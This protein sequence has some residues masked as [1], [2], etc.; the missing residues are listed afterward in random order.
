MS[1]KVIGCVLVAIL[2]AGLGLFGPTTALAAPANDDFDAATT[3]GALPFSD[4]ADTRSATAAAD[5][6]ISCSNN[7][8]VWYS[9]TVSQ[10]AVVTADT[11]G[12][13]YDT[14]LSVF[15]GSRGALSLIGCNDD[16]VG[17]QSRVT[18]SAA[19]GTTYFF[20]VAFCCG[21][22][23]AGGGQLVFHVSTPAAPV[24]DDFANARLIDSLP[25]SDT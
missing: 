18:F 14:V 24:N 16:T 7:G 9:L 10:S 21:A 25:L 2:S 23:G 11:F 6:P 8:S 4:S 15:T 22:G 3:I 19:A 17:I 13:N 5:D 12:S 20:M 1:R